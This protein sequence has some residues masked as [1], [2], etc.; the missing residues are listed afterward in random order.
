VTREKPFLYVNSAGNFNAFV[1]ALQR[2][3]SGITWGNGPAPGSSI[4]ITDFFIAQPTDDVDKINDA[5]ACGKHLILT[6]GIYNLDEPI[7]VLRPDTVVLGLGFPTLVPRRGK[8][9]ME[10]ANVPGVKLSGLIFD[11]GPV[12]SRV[13]LKVGELPCFP[14]LRGAGSD[15]NNPTLIQDVFFRIGGGWKASGA[16]ARC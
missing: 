16:R 1:P 3:S 5:L 9:S 4:P 11:A 12:N 7:R 8:E 15:P 13:L 10:I 6:P 2:N 14:I